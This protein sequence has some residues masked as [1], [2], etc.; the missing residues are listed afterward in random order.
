VTSK[1]GP[2]QQP[3]ASPRG[4]VEHVSPER[5]ERPQPLP[6]EAVA[7]DRVELSEVAAAQAPQNRAAPVMGSDPVMEERIRDIRARIA[8]GTYLTPD[9]IDAAV[10]GLY[11]DLIGG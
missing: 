9:K 3:P 1:I 6:A 7:G 10:D 11:R 2:V 4:Q 8:D 5:E